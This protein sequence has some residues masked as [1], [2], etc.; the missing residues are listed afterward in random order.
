MAS[1]AILVH[2]EE[3]RA[4]EERITVAEEAIALEKLREG[5]AKVKAKNAKEWEARRE[6]REASAML[7]KAK[8]DS[9]D[10]NRADKGRHGLKGSYGS[11]YD[12]PNLPE[13]RQVRV[14]HAHRTQGD[15]EVAKATEGQR[16]G[17][18]EDVGRGLQHPPEVK[19]LPWARQ[20]HHPHTRA[21]ARDAKG[22]EN[23]SKGQVQSRPNKLLIL[24]ANIDKTIAYHD[25][26]LDRVLKAKANLVLVQEPW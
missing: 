5:W 16:Q 7:N 18:G 12:E 15:R 3:E 21:Q 2:E 11:Q 10:W 1:M 24:Q 20:D 6:Y 13:G 22:P 23:Q 26:I 9:F 14:P 4:L 19:L 25:T 17:L 8:S